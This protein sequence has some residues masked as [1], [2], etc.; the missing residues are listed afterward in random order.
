VVTAGIDA[1]KNHAIGIFRDGD[2]AFPFRNTEK[3]DLQEAYA[4][5]KFPV[6]EG[7][8]LKAGK[9]NPWTVADSVPRRE[10]AGAAHVSSA[11]AAA[12]GLSM[13]PGRAAS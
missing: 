7:L 13:T 4:S 5:W 12:R 11:R 3:F 2:D 8:T 9:F 6:A 1:Q 10:L